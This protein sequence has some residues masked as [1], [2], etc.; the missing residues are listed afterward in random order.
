MTSKTHLLYTEMMSH[1][2]VASF[3]LSIMMPLTPLMKKW[4]YPCVYTMSAIVLT[5]AGFT[6]L[7][8]FPFFFACILLEV[9]ETFCQNMRKVFLWSDIFV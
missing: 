8:F 5:G 2:V 7:C 4:V 6:K 9:L 3:D 1:S